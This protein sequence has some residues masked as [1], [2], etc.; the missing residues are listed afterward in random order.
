MEN[1]STQKADSGSQV[2]SKVWKRLRIKQ[3]VEAGGRDAEY[4]REMI[5]SPGYANKLSQQVKESGS[6]SPFGACWTTLRKPHLFL[7]S[8]ND[9]SL[10]ERVQQ[11]ATRLTQH[12]EQM[13]YKESLKEPASSA[14]RREGWGWILQ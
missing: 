7:T 3:Q 6:S 2:V 1:R 14:A 4:Q 8:Q 5:C 10:L 11:R 9:I 12:L 13:T